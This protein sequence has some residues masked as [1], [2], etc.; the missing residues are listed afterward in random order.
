MKIIVMLMLPLCLF[1]QLRAQQ[2]TAPSPIIF[3]YDASGSMLGKIQGQTKKEIASEVLTKAVGNL[4]DN[5]QVGLVAYGHRQKDD[6]MDVEFLVDVKNGTKANVIKSL[7]KISPL[8]KT[9]LAYSAMRVIESLRTSKMKSTI[10]LVT[11][12]I[13]SC[14]GDICD[15]IEAAK[16]EGIDF[17]LHIVG[18][19][20][21]ATETEQ[22]KCA[23]KAGDGQYYDAADAG[24]LSDVLNDATTATVDKPKYNFTVYA[25]KNGQPIDAYIKAVKP[26]ENKGVALARTYRDTGRMY[27]PDGTY[28]LIVNP[29]EGSDVQPIVVTDVQSKKGEP[30]HRTVSFDAGKLSVA[31]LNNGN[32]WD[33]VVKIYAGGKVI[34]SGRTYERKKVFDINPGTYNIVA[35]IMRIEGLETKKRI[36]SV[37]VKAGGQSEIAFEFNSGIAMIG[38]KTAN[39]LVDAVVKIAEVKSRKVVASARTYTSVN[40]NPKKFL[41]NPGTYEVSLSTLGKHKGKT[42]KFTLVVKENE[43]VENMTIF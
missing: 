37:A 41:L 3:I 39:E 11:D 8:G 14:D 28:N 36:D 20:L 30:M 7:A 6:C 4:P 34:A 15:V 13:K 27:L 42:K 22:L 17:R 32:G 23:A 40:N 18:F 26:G 12:G 9:P 35:E 1:I 33:A 5:L 16:K 24:G 19:G 10:I 25:V 21:K 29:M 31:T 2:P 43:T 38:V